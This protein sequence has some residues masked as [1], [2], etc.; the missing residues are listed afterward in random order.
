MRDI[1]LPFENPDISFFSAETVAR[2][3]FLILIKKAEGRR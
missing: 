1:S 3:A 2:W